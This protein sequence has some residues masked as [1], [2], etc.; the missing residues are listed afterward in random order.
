MDGVLMRSMGVLDRIEFPRSFQLVVC[1]ILTEVAGIV[2]NRRMIGTLIAV[3]L[4]IIAI[5]NV[6]TQS[7]QSYRNTDKTHSPFDK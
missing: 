2:L 1:A 6:R 4:F 5:S 3:L 7:K